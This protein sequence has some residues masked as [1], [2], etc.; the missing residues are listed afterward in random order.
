M[1]SYNSVSELQ[2]NDHY[3]IYLVCF[4]L[5]LFKLSVELQ[6]LLM[7]FFFRD[8]G[9][10]LFEWQVFE[11]FAMRPPRTGRHNHLKRDKRYPLVSD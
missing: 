8:R 1:K 3:I 5:P 7:H 11:L 4:S 9:Q 10:Q 6:A 2:T